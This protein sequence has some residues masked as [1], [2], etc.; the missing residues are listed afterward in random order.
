MISFLALCQLKHWLVDFYFQTNEMV[1][2]K[3]IYGNKYGM[4]HSLQHGLMM[5]IVAGLFTDL[6]LAIIIAV[7]DTLVH[8]H[9]DWFRM[10]YGSGDT[11]EKSFWM[12]FGLDQMAH[13]I[14]YLILA[15]IIFL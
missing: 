12:H 11:K 9:I 1:R 2:G 10:N 5:L 4:V 6:Q 7:A 3:G 13:Q 8:Y 14:T 15:V